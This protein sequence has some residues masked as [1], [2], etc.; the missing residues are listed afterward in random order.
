MSYKNGSKIKVFNEIK[1]E[2][3]VHIFN[4][5]ETFMRLV[6]LSFQIFE[7]RKDG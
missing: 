3:S 4:S 6:L 1:M 5:E 7:Q 2:F